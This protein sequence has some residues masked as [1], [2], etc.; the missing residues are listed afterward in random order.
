M[1]IGPT[2]RTSTGDRAV[3]AAQAAQ[4]LPDNPRRQLAELADSARQNMIDKADLQSSMK[5]KLLASRNRADEIRQRIQNGYYSRPE[6]L[7]SIA[8]R[9]AE[10]MQ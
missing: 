2:S 1:K 3:G 8:D 4:P 6:I 10:D 9:V 7:R 5:D